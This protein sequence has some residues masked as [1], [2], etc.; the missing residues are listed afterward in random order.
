MPTMQVDEALADQMLDKAIQTCA[1]LRF[2]GDLVQTHQAMHLGRCDICA[3]VSECLVRQV[4]EY[5]GKMDRTVKS[6]YQYEPQFPSL[7]PNWEDPRVSSRPA[8]INMVA[9]VERKSAA[10]TALCATLEKVLSESRQR[11]RCRNA[12]PA[13]YILDIQMIEDRD[14]HESRG[15]GMV[16]NNMAVRSVQVWRREDG[17][18]R[19]GSSLREAAPLEMQLL[20]ASYDPEFSPENVLFEQ[21]AAIEKLPPEERQPY[22]H[23]LMEIKVALIRRMI[24]DQL[25]YI[26]IAKEWFTT[27]DLADVYRRK[28]C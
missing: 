10:L 21:A 6:V 22:E 26:H 1:D 18:A 17:M 27:A 16:V 24:S 13:C 3:T 19:T 5:L 12:C 25:A 15:Y 20:L 28:I 23:R 11:F 14:V 9:W 2:H 7:R 4:G 8:G